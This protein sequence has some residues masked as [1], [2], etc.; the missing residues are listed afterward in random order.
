MSNYFCKTGILLTMAC[1]SLCKVGTS[2]LDIDVRP[3][4][5][6]LLF[7]VQM[8]V[9]HYAICSIHQKALWRSDRGFVHPSVRAI[10][11]ILK[12]DSGSAMDNSRVGEFKK[13]REHFKAYQLFSLKPA[14]SSKRSERVSC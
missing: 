8:V 6:K 5:L 11:R 4:A 1:T 7:G 9:V 13:I 2:T 14:T 3:D 12:I 10:E